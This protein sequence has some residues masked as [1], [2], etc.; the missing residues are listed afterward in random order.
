MINL[1]CS[2]SNFSWKCQF[3]TA[4]CISWVIALSLTFKTHSPISL[5]RHIAVSY[6]ENSCMFV[7]LIKVLTIKVM[8]YSAPKANHSF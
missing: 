4:T 8:D 6:A 5:C 7:F 1:M 2:Q 3:A